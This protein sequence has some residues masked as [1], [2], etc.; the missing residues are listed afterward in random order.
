MKKLYVAKL[1]NAD[2]GET[3]E[4]IA[5]GADPRSAR[6]DAWLRLKD[7]LSRQGQVEK[8]GRYFMYGI[9]EIRGERGK[10]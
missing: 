3:S 2:T 1:Y 8:F 10:I 4:I 7:L 9:A 6:L 5:R